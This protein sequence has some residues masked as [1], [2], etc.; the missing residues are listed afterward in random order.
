MARRIA[1]L[2]LGVVLAAAAGNPPD[3]SGTWV[4]NAGKSKNIGMMA[5]AEY[6]STIRQT[7]KLLSVSDVTMFG[8]Q[9]QTYQTEYDLTG[10]T[11]PKIPRWARKARRAASGRERNW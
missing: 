5:G 11:V 8:G 10:T 3:F 7:P 1:L 2:F 6:T 9:K 4:F